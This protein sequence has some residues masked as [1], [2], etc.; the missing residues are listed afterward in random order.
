MYQEERKLEEQIY[1]REEKKREEQERLEE[2]RV[3][4]APPPS[5]LDP[6]LFPQ[7]KSPIP[8]NVYKNSCA[9]WTVFFCMIAFLLV[10]AGLVSTYIALGGF[11]KQENH[12]VEPKGYDPRHG[13]APDKPEF[14][15]SFND[16]VRPNNF[17]P[18]LNEKF[19]YN[20][21][22]RIRGINLGGWLVLEPFITPRIF[23][24]EIPNS[25]VRVIDEWTLCE[26]LGAEEATKQLEHHY[27]TFI[28]EDDFRKIAEMG[29]NHIRIPTGHWALRTFPGEP[30]VPYVSWQYLIRGIQWAR[31]YGLR[32]MVELHTAPGSQNGWNHSGRSGQVG[33]LNGTDGQL[34][35][36]RTLEIA[37]EMVQFFNKPE[38]SNVVTLFGV[39]NEPAMMKIPVDKVKGW[40][41]AS[42]NSIR[43][44][45]GPDNGPLLT[46]H[47]GFYPLKEW[48][49]FFGKQYQRVV[50]GKCCSDLMQANKLIF[51][52]LFFRN[53]LVYDL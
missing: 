45:L 5:P 53:T 1:E 46:Y 8:E 48:N 22:D 32:V 33:F 13:H 18:P 10:I 51:L 17:T 26:Q 25:T 21:K 7:P 23:E 19:G 41:D 27:R 34:N 40:Y 24:Q 11:K 14:G 28:T 44:A 4:A 36:E 31:K 42:Y 47:D 3:S 30:F 20:E 52:S 12:Y 9:S 6:E 2:Q 50:L 29:F 39:L 43:K 16:N 15:D 35:A 37:T 49:G 38:W